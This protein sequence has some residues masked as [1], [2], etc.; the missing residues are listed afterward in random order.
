[1]RDVASALN[2]L[3]PVFDLR[4]AAAVG[5]SARVVE[6]ALRGR[7]VR[8]LGCGVFVA[9]SVWRES[10]PRDRHLLITAAAAR[11]RPWLL[12]ATTVPHAG[13]AFLFR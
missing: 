2:L 8:R 7:L 10:S 9:E 13:S 6:R 5:L 1:M 4:Q 12:S 3:P 11:L